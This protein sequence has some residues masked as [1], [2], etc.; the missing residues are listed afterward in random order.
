MI[1]AGRLGVFLWWQSRLSDNFGLLFVLIRRLLG[2]F[3]AR[4]LRLLFFWSIN[5]VLGLHGLLF[6]HLL[7]FGIDVVWCFGLICALGGRLAR[8]HRATLCIFHQRLA[9]LSEILII[10]HLRRMTL[11]N[12][13]E[14]LLH[15]LENNL[16]TF[17]KTCHLYFYY[18]AD[19]SFVVSEVLN[20]LI[21]LNDAGHAE[22]QATEHDSLLDVFDEGQDV[23]VNVQ[24]ADIGNIPINKAVSNTLTRVTQDLV[25]QFR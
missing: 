18:F 22:I 1:T 24:S 13:I 19:A 4:G 12:Y 23:R 11:T 6:F 9:L 8:L 16:A 17:F 20:T 7:L 3:K 5:F 2:N 14:R 21:I 25:I 10:K 15:V